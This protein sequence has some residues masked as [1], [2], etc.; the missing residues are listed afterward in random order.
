MPANHPSWISRNAASATVA[1]AFAAVGCST[2]TEETSVWKSPTY[3]AGPMKNIAVFGGRLSESERRT[4]EDGLV[5]RLAAHGVHATPSYEILT[6]SQARAD[7][8]SIRA[9][10]RND[11]YDGAL[12]STL[13][14]ISEQVVVASDAYWAGAFYGAYWGTTPVAATTERF[15]KFETTLWDPNSG[16]MVWSAVTQT[17]NPTSGKDFVSSLGNAI[18]PSLAKAGLVPPRQESQSVSLAR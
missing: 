5:S 7:S 18:V 1:L 12:V 16:K 15:V 13:K 8:A 9:T 2:S 14:G 17:A 6:E 10:L 4:L 11:G 3:A